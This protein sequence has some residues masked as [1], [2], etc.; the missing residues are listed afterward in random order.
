MNSSSRYA[1]LACPIFYSE[2]CSHV[3]SLCSVIYTVVRRHL[4]LCC[5]YTVL[6]CFSHSPLPDHSSPLTL[7]GRHRHSDLNDS[8]NLWSII[9]AT[10]LPT[11]GRFLNE[12]R[13]PPVATKSDFGEQGWGL[14]IQLPSKDSESQQAFDTNQN[15]L[16][17]GGMVA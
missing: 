7:S 8:G 12:C 2:T 14:M 16:G 13:E 15:L 17:E 11:F 5:V 9:S 4:S 1:Q 3:Y 10:Y 6:A